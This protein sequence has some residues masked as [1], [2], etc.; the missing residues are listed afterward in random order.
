MTTGIVL[1]SSSIRELFVKNPAVTN[2]AVPA[3]NTEQTLTLAG[4]IRR[5]T[6]KAR[7]TAA[8]RI[9]FSPTETATNYISIPAG[10]VFTEENFEAPTQLYFSTD[11]IDTVEILTWVKA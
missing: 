8:L 1:P 5:I 4:T 6:I 10:A 2:I 7:G 3:A 9:A 11:K